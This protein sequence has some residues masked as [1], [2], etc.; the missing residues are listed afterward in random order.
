[1]PSS[2]V[3]LHAELDIGDVEKGLDA[4]ERRA[5]AVGPVFRK[6]VGPMREDQT[7]HAKREAGPLAKWARRKQST[8]EFYRNRKRGRVPK[9]MGRLTKFV[10]Y[11]GDELGVFAASRLWWTGVF[12]E[13]GTVGRGAKIKPRIFLWISR[14]LLDKAADA[15]EQALVSAYGSGR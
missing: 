1:M 9:P 11:K 3:Y 6:L 7:D 15:L 4:M 8:I 13:G 2:G 10:R 12:M 5:H 14:R